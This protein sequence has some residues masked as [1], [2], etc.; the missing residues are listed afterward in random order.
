MTFYAFNKNE[1]MISNTKR[2]NFTVQLPHLVLIDIYIIDKY[3]AMFKSI[4]TGFQY[5]NLNSFNVTE[6]ITKLI[7]AI[8]RNRKHAVENLLIF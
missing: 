2:I 3:C 5:A 1:Y 8:K 7:T 4:Y 6:H